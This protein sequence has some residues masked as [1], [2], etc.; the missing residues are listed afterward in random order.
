MNKHSVIQFISCGKTAAGQLKSIQ[1]MLDAGVDWIQ[2]RFK[3][4]KQAIRWNTAA[5][6]KR[7]CE[8]YKATLI[9]NDDVALA[10]EVDA[11][12]VH[13]GL[14]DTPVAEA[15]KRLPGK[16]I[17]GTANTLQDV[18]QRIAERVDYIGLGPLHYTTTKEHLSPLLGYGGYHAILSQLEK[19]S[20]PPVY[21][22][23]GIR[24]EDIQQL[25]SAGV[26]GIAVS[27]MLHHAENKRETL[28]LIKGL[29]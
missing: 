6:V 13:L 28:R 29:L 25:K 2:F 12:G 14:Q 19:G 5:I 8:R 24:Y 15:K 17:G 9:I 18:K 10:G 7:E 16:L 22:I 4:E 23:G 27:G 11:H 26:Y 3:E 1:E 20:Y 21:A